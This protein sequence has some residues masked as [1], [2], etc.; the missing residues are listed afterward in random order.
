MH[1]C[2]KRQKKLEDV[3]YQKERAHYKACKEAAYPRL[4]SNPSL[5]TIP[6]DRPWD[7]TDSFTAKWRPSKELQALDGLAPER[8][9]PP[10]APGPLVA[11]PPAL[12]AAAA[13]AA[14]AEAAAAVERSPRA[15]I[16]RTDTGRRGT[17]V[18]LEAVACE[19]QEQ[20]QPTVLDAGRAAEEQGEQPPQASAQQASTTEQEELPAVSPS[21]SSHQSQRSSSPREA[22]A[23]LSKERRCAL[24]GQRVWGAGLVGGPPESPALPQALD[25]LSD[26]S[27][28]DD[29]D[30]RWPASRS[31]P[32][33]RARADAKGARAGARGGAENA[34]QQHT[35]RRRR[36][37]PFC[38]LSSVEGE[39]G[40]AHD[41]FGGSSPR[42]SG[43]DS[44]LAGGAAAGA[45]PMAPGG[46]APAMQVAA[47]PALPPLVV[48]PA[49]P[50]LAAGGAG[51]AA[52]PGGRLDRGSPSIDD[53]ADSL[54]GGSP[55][56]AGSVANTP[57]C[58]VARTACGAP[59]RQLK[60]SAPPPGWQSGGHAASPRAGSCGGGSSRDSSLGRGCGRTAFGRVDSAR[61]REVLG[62][63]ID[64]AGPLAIAST[65]S[66]T[67]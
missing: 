49:P 52:Q 41:G 29:A 56:W 67:G 16:V 21:S 51:V 39:E 30:E 59:P 40:S 19:E 13:K 50:A 7:R 55:S 22:F 48:R 53:S 34:A 4:A 35:P 10:P 12:L 63:P 32:D 44:L 27:S 38:R 42:C 15:R 11:L 17:L 31:R 62:A 58:A 1:V 60:Q 2:C 14:A 20:R 43:A 36:R 23:S 8:P 66:C 65:V 26:S 46:G 54:A 28:S 37:Q 57:P 47:P 6:S 5:R 9:P 3:R 45:S 61:E 18:A 25:P 33:A 64:S 24:S